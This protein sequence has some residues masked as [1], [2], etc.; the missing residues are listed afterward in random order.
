MDK[1][2]L[3]DANALIHRAYHALPPMNTSDGTP[4]NAVFGFTTMLMKVFTTLKPT[5][6]LA[7]F[8]VKG[9][10]FRKE[11]YKEYKA[12]RKAAPDDLVPQFDLVRE[13]LTAFAIPILQQQGFEADDII[14]TLVETLPQ[15]AKKIIVTGDMDA[16]QLVNENTV[17]FTLR[18]GVT[19][20]ITYDIE[21][22]KEKLGF[23][24]E[25]VI[26]YKGLRG[27][28]SD[29]IP[30]V[31]GIGDKT[32]T[33]LIAMFGSV[34]NIFKHIDEV[35]GRAKKALEGHEQEAFL[36][37][38]LATIKRDI[39]LTFSLEDA[40]LEEYDVKHV[41]EIFRKL[42]FHSLLQKLP[43][44]Q[45]VTPSLFQNQK[46]G[47]SQ[48]P[49][50]YLLVDT[51]QE[52]EKL[53]K[54]LLQETLIAFDTE[55]DSLGARSYP[56][57]GMS[58]AV[59]RPKGIQA[60]YVPVIP[61]SVKDWKEL[62]E[63]SAVQK[64]GHN[65]KYDAEVLL[66]SDI[67]LGGIAFDTMLAAYLL[68][69]SGR[70]YSLDALAAEELQHTTIPLSSLIGSGKDQKR[71]S[72]AP[73]ADL[74]CY[75]CEDAD[76]ALQLYEIFS[77]RIEENGLRRVMYEIEAPLISVLADMENTGVELDT[78]TLKKMNNSIVQEIEALKQSIW[79]TAGKEFNI[80]ST[81]Q[82]KEILFDTLALPTVGIKRTKTGYSTASSELGKLR[83]KHEIISYI[84]KYRELT[85]LQSTYIETLPETVDPRDGRIHTTYN[86]IGAA[87]G[88]LGSQDPN[89]QNIP[90]RT[91]LGQDIRR[92][93]V[94]AKGKVLVKA[95]YSQMELRLA[96]HMSQDEKND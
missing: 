32:A 74:A 86:Q 67:H 20:T 2:A 55:N 62:L 80:K 21:T 57:V 45:E 42:E 13:V 37:K 65:L 47:K 18:R 89:L 16:L 29:N 61:E 7:A 28:P 6:V 49:E 38:Q 82:L 81:N 77:K 17:V 33:D 34:E 94:S 90:V 76:I 64:T 68:N 12:H 53:R 59:R 52:Q 95:D 54:E 8:D 22:V 69:P 63:S 35:P 4:T 23:G 79:K 88:R 48:M 78:K 46:A 44:G 66:Q 40:R 60:W 83:D 92:A 11:L 93:F 87:T 25:H 75:A 39:P 27:D 5:H 26:D 1:I 43:G 50:N 9:P 19:D 73:L 14:G 72:E 24:P 91:K 10:T 30:G 51:P 71:V 70:S 58:F 15:N 56:I 84:E 96:A 41:E 3:I 36:S 31:A 85:K